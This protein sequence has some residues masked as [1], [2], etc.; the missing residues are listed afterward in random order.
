MYLRPASVNNCMHE[1]L[2]DSEFLAARSQNKHYYFGHRNNIG[3]VTWDEVIDYI[4]DHHARFP[5]CIRF[6]DQL[7]FTVINNWD[8]KI[9]TKEPAAITALRQSYHATKPELPA[10]TSI[11]VS[12]SKNAGVV[13]WHQ[14]NYDLL[15]WCALG[16]VQISVK[17][18]DKIHS[19]RL[20]KDYLIWLPAGAPHNVRPIEPRVVVSTG[21]D[22]PKPMY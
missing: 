12:L 9:A 7:G 15:L 8:G 17:E 18:D 21:L 14:D 13:G 4:G 1:F 6:N 3:S 19:Y 22:Y 10:R 2:Q 11:F 16:S 5:D 20:L